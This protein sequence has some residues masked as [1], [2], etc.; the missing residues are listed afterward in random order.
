MNGLQYLVSRKLIIAS[1]LLAFLSASLWTVSFS[2]V[3]QSPAQRK[4]AT[5][6]FKDMPIV[7]SQVRNLEKE[8]HWFRDLQIE[9]KNISDK[10]I[11]FVAI[12]LEFPDIEAPSSTSRPDGLTPARTVIGFPL[13]FGRSELGDLSKRATPDDVALKPGESYVF[14]IPES[15][16]TGFERMK[17]RM[18]ISVEATK[19]I[20]IRIDAISFGDGTGFV[21]GK[22]SL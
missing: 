14:T 8:P 20:T 9:V 12:G 6:T 13:K 1:L 7:V 10:P 21:A 17:K 2:T 3:A 19:N 5:K 16:A 18:N 22:K 11:Y 15:R 4:I